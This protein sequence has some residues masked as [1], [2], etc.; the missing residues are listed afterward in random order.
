MPGKG[1]VGQSRLFVQRFLQVALADIRHPGGRGLP[2]HRRR[3]GLADR[4]QGHG[5]GR[6]AGI[7]FRCADAFPD[8]CYIELDG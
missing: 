6:A 8:L 4:D 2:D 7:F 1:Q 3:P 5:T